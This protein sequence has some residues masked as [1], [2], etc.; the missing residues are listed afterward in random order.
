[1]KQRICTIHWLDKCDHHS[2]LP[3]CED[4]EEVEEVVAVE[5]VEEIEEIDGSIKSTDVL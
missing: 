3:P 5:E 4:D 1:M 2:Y